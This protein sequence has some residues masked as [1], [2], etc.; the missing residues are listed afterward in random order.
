[1][2][3]TTLFPMCPQFTFYIFLHLFNLLNSNFIILPREGSLRRYKKPR[4]VLPYVSACI[5]TSWER[6]IIKW[7]LINCVWKMYTVFYAHLIVQNT[8]AH[9]YN[10]TERFTDIKSPVKYPP[11]INQN[12]ECALNYSAGSCVSVIENSFRNR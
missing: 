7:A 12:A 4:Q 6:H 5:F 2:W 9:S 3:T 10:V 8:T 1:M 11:L